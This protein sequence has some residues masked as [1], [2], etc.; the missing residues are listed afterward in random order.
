MGLSAALIYAPACFA[1]TDE[2]IELARVVAEHDA[3]YISHIRNESAQLL[4]AVEELITIARAS[5]VTAEIYHL[6]ASGA[7]NWH[8]MEMAIAAVE[9][10]RAQGLAHHGGH[11]YL[12]LIPALAWIPAFRPGRTR[13]ASRP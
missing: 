10:A 8:R 1:Q 9:A 12:H 4:E 2:L 7:D 6:K 3:M 11:V 5:G 13:V